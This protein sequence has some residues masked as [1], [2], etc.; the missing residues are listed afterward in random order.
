MVQAV[1]EAGLRERSLSS[2][3]FAV[4]AT[5]GDFRGSGEVAPGHGRGIA[6]KFQILDVFPHSNHLV[7]KV[8]HLHPGGEDWFIEH[9]VF[10]GREGLK[11]KRMVNAEGQ[12][13]MDNGNIAPKRG[14]PDRPG[15]SE[16]FLPSGHDWARN[17]PP[18]MDE[19]SVLQIIQSTHAERTI[20]GWEGDDILSELSWHQEDEDGAGILIAKLSYLKGRA[21]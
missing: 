15:K 11:R 21:S 4:G 13:L 19:T 14:I 17:P 12:L 7:V 16:Q 9:Y 10:Q 3:L 5:T 8:Q 20:S 6:V 18:Y 1:H 2:P